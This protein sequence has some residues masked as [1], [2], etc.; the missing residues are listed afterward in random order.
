M[1]TICDLQEVYTVTL[2]DKKEKARISKISFLTEA[3]GLEL[4]ALY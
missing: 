2:L 4:V 1:F 3:L